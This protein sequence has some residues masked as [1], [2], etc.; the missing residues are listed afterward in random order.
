MRDA[1]PD[2]SGEV[3]FNEFAGALQQQIDSGNT[4]GGLAA[5]TS[6]AGS[7]FGFLNPFSWFATEPPPKPVPVNLGTPNMIRGLPPTKQP[8]GGAPP[9]QLRP[10]LSGGP[11]MWYSH[12]S[13][14]RSDSFR[15][16]AAAY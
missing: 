15:R 7:F 9:P 6:Q 5:I 12:R 13:G 10:A 2:G 11:D 16:C 14:Q 4:A 3:D 8:Q 1:D